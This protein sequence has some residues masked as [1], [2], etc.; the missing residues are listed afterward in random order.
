MKNEEMHRIASLALEELTLRNMEAVVWKLREQRDEMTREI[1]EK[2]HK[3][4]ELFE[5]ARSKFIDSEE[6]AKEAYRQ[7][8]VQKVLNLKRGG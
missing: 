8:V 3:A 1:D 4:E 6:K 2:I 5:N 7:E